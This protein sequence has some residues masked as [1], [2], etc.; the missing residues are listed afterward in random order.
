MPA[1]QNQIKREKRKRAM[2]ARYM[3]KGARKLHCAISVD[4]EN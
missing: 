4:E 3:R 2:S 1:T